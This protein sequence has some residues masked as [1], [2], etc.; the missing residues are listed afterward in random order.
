MIDLTAATLIAKK[1]VQDIYPSDTDFDV[2]EIET[3]EDQKFW[4]ITIG[5]TGS[6]KTENPLF[7]LANKIRRYKSVQIDKENG[8][9]ISMKIRKV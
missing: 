6:A 8:K 3:T 7:N 4:I 1:F 9:V 5:M 2:E